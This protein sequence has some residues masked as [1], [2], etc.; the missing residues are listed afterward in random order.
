MVARRVRDIYGNWVWE[1]S[2]GA[3]KSERPPNTERN[4]I[5]ENYLAKGGKTDRPTEKSLKLDWRDYVALTIASLQ[6]VLMPI[7]V[8]I[9]LLV[10]LA[11]ILTH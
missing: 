9:V 7:I 1:D 3:T 8:M 4:S 2:D 10:V 11:L 6:T 5:R